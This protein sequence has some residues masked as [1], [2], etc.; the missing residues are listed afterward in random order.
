MKLKYANFER[1]SRQLSLP[2]P[3]DDGQTLYRSA[4]SLLERVALARPVRLTG[5][6]AHGLTGGEGQLP[7]FSEEKPQAVRARALNS[8]LDSIS[9]KYG[10]RAVLPA[11]VASEE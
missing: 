3:T 4:M 5:V 10:R 8:A 1:I 2:E 9:E 11:D 6:S 7:L